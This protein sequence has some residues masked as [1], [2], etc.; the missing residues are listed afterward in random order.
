[1]LL[2]EKEIASIE[3]DLLEH[4]CWYDE[5]SPEFKNMTNDMD[6]EEIKLHTDKTETG[7]CYCDSCFRGKQYL[8]SQGLKLIE[9]IKAL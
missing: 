7:A 5:R 4:L 1:M 3:K 9:H 8:A 6:K 2:T